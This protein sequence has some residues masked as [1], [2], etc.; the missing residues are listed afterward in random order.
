[1]VTMDAVAEFKKRVKEI[2]LPTFCN[3]SKRQYGTEGFRDA[4][5]D[6]GEID[7]RDCMFAID[8]RLIVDSGGGRY[9]AAK[10]SAIEQLFTEGSHAKTPRPITLWLEPVITFAALA[11]LHRD[12]HWPAP[13]LGTQPPGWAFDLAAHSPSIPS[14]YHILCEVKKS[15]QEVER[16]QTDL[17]LLC[18]KPDAE[19]VRVNS[20]KKWNALLAAKAPILWLLGPAEYSKVMR[21]EY[22]ADDLPV[23]STA[24]ADA[25]NYEA[26]Q[27]SLSG[28][29]AG[30]W[31]A[32]V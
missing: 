10:N 26:A 18:S 9:R 16:L 6:I 4:S 12:H 24:P 19:T 14:R 5:M 20:R 2:W 13:L 15:I 11:R 29:S 30:R 22:P 8:Y 31:T 28:G 17:E 1:M 21:V 7:A 3:D 32:T 25:L 23:L 27:P